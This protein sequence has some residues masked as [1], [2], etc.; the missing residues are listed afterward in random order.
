[1]DDGLYKDRS[2]VVEVVDC[3]VGE[4]GGASTVVQLEVRSKV[5]R[6]SRARMVFMGRWLFG[7]VLCYL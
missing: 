7:Y 2:V 5:V 3:T 1:M 4:G 6:P